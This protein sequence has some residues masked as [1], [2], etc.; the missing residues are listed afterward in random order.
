MRPTISLL[1]SVPPGELPPSPPRYLFGRD[2]LVEEI[3]GL[4]E[5][6]APIALIGPPGIGKTAVALTVLHHDRIKQRFG[7]NRR[8]IR[9]DQFPASL[10]NFLS[11]LSE[12]IGAGVKK[13]KHLDSL[14][15]F[16]SSREMIVILD[17]AESILDPE[18]T[19][20][21]EIYAAVEELSK[22]DGICVCITSRITLVPVVCEDLHIPT[23]SMKTA[24][25][26]FYSNYKDCEVSNL[27]DNVLMDLD[28]HPLSITL[29]AAAAHQNDWDIDQLVQVWESQ[30]TAMLHTH[31]NESLTA[32]IELSLASPTFRGLGPHGREALEVI[33]FFSQGI[34]E[35]HLD[36]LFPR[37]PSEITSISDGLYTLSLTKKRNGSI[38]MLAPLRDYLRQKDPALSSL[39]Y[40]IQRRLSA[41]LNPD[42]PGPEEVRWVD[43]GKSERL[44]ACR[45][46]FLLDD[47]CTCK[48]ERKTA[49]EHFKT[50]LGIASSCNWRDQAFWI[51]HRLAVLFFYEDRLD[52]AYAHVEHAKS[53]AIDDLYMMGH[54]MRLQAGFWYNED[55]IEEA[56]SEASRAIDVFEQFGAAQDL[57][58]CGLM[59]QCIETRR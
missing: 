59:L 12:A 55:R 7:D 51:H 23:L 50:A 22:L 13:P 26:T 6:L 52:E 8:L 19:N 10:S 53:H 24:R 45:Y 31:Y 54:A 11:K 1:C 46:Y 48:G 17:N 30:G 5:N 21:H 39:P 4:A 43:L 42:E 34:N 49:I 15:P 38:T 33:A 35:E 14:R 25:D 41:D 56:R 27:I 9:C 44:Q 28:F 32:S 20:I 36:W 3:V 37:A 40:A 2:E 58:C 16:L 57:A 29:L 47:M 18:G